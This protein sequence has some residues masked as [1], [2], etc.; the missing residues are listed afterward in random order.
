MSV[1]SEISSQYLD[2]V[3]EQHANLQYR[4]PPRVLVTGAQGQRSIGREIIKH[5]NGSV[6]TVNNDDVKEVWDPEIFDDIDTLIM[7]H[8]QSHLDWFEEADLFKVYEIITVNLFGTFNVA[9]TFVKATIDKPYRKRI[10]SIGSMAYK[11]VLNGSAAYCAS[12]AG[13]A[14]LIKCL[15]WELAPKGYDVY[16]IHP[17]NTLDTPMSDQTIAGLKRYRNMSTEDAICYW[18]DSMIRDESLTKAEIA[19]VI[20]SIIDN[21]LGYLSGC[22]IELSGGQR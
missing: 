11:A 21:K 13:Q 16:C 2:E 8:G 4:E 10:I 7:C 18:N 14:H 17:S 1:K 19:R 15:A 20:T 22:N 5:L 3:K 6:V 12:K 9:Q